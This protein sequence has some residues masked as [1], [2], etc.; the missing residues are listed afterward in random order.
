MRAKPNLL[1]TLPER[2]HHLA[3]VVR[4]QEVNRKFF[5][6]LLGIPLVATWCEKV[7]NKDL[8]REIEYCHTFFGVGDSG[9]LAFFQYADESLYEEPTVNPVKMSGFR[10]VAF[11]VGRATFDELDRRI[12][13]AGIAK[14]ITDHGYCLSLYVI[15]P[16]KLRV[17]FT[18]D[19]PDIAKIDAMRRAD[20]HAE[21]A[22]WLAGD[23]RTNNDDRP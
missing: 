17:E 1:P 18:V 15:S 14:R 20:A 16:D 4:D 11:K 2:L 7:F 23:R 3:Y 22:R 9:A 12:T 5:E 21:L 10:H 8:G 19:P 13:A 6:D